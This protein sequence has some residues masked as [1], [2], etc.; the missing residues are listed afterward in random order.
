MKKIALICLVL[1]FPFGQTKALSGE[2]FY[3]CAKM[4]VFSALALFSLFCV[5]LN[6]QR[7]K[8]KNCNQSPTKKDK[9]EPDKTIF[10]LNIMAIVLSKVAMPTFFAYFARKSYKQLKVARA[11]KS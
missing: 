8:Q 4:T 5:S 9:L 11:G 10:I 2:V 6:V 1:F 3:Y 7:D